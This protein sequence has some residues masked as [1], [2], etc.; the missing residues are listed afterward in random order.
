MCFH[1]SKAVL[2][3]RVLFCYVYFVSSMQS[4]QPCGH[5]LGKGWPPC[6]LVCDVFLCFCPCGVLG[7]VWNLIVSIPDLCLLSYFVTRA[8]IIRVYS[9]ELLS[10]QIY[11][12]PMKTHHSSDA[13]ICCLSKA[14]QNFVIYNYCLGQMRCFLTVI[15]ILVTPLTHDVTSASKLRYSHLG[16]I[17]NYPKISFKCFLF[18]SR[19]PVISPQL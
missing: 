5:L 7:Q 6:Y 16:R 18:A 9:T 17:Q 12:C 15:S 8:G 11:S 13:H 2:H 1:R 10:S 4:L 19:S 3:L 14:V